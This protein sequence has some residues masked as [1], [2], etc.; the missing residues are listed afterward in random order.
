MSGN[1]RSTAPTLVASCRSTPTTATVMPRRA[2]R[3]RTHPAATSASPSKTVD[4]PEVFV[5]PDVR[6][7]VDQ[8]NEGQDSGHAARWF[9]SCH[10]GQHV[11]RDP[12]RRR[13]A[14]GAQPLLRRRWPFHGRGRHRSRQTAA[15]RGAARPAHRPGPPATMPGVAEASVRFDAA[16][17][18]DESPVR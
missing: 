5:L 11:L 2:A 17:P 18:C 3:P 1:T 4:Q 16:G 8:R 10:T 15:A 14:P 9:R 7:V 12:V 13:A 6:L